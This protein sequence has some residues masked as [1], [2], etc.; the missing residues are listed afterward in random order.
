MH[1][2][3]L[4]H[5]LEKQPSSYAKKKNYKFHKMI[6]EGTFGDVKQATWTRE[7]GQ[8]QEVAVKCIRK[9]L[10][11]SKP[12]VV[13]DEMSVLKDLDHPKIVKIYDWF[14]SKDTYYL[15]FELV[16][17]GELFDRIVK[18]HHF[19][20]HDA[21]ICIRAI[22][23]AVAYLH[24]KDICHRDIKPENLLLRSMDQS[25]LDDIVLADFGVA[26]HLS[27]P[28]ERSKTLVGSPGYSAPEVL[29]EDNYR[30]QPADIWSIGVIAHAMLCGSTPFQQNQSQENLLRQQLEGKIAF[31][32]PIWQEISSEAKDFIKACCKVKPEERLT[33][34]EALNHPWL[35]NET[36]RGTHDIGG[37]ARDAIKGRMRRTGSLVE[38]DRTRDLEPHER[39]ES[40]SSSSSISREEE[41]EREVSEKMSEVDLT[42]NS[43]TK[44]NA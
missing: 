34:D 16:P 27:E 32:K 8:Q 24:H 17:G 18:L 43:P 23:E 41:M 40:E 44:T 13:Y 4:S 31:D 39:E 35:I 1:L 11:K 12:Q 36:S 30:G 20:E 6:G 19:S 14:E 22:L 37:D 2:G 38:S 7:D 10:V 15:V 9:K 26:R 21:A 42:K 25:K 33:A 5:M 29:C 3:N 28:M